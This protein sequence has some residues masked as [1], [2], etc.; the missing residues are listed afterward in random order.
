[1]FDGEGWEGEN[2]MQKH[3]QI[4]DYFAKERICNYT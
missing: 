3:K 1:M 4:I 2:H